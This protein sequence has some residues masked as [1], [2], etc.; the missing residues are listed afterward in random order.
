MKIENRDIIVVGIQPWDIE[1]GSNCKDIAA[2][3]S[4]HN[5]V[6]YINN[7]ISKHTAKN[8]PDSQQVKNRLE[9]N[10]DPSK[11][12]K[13]ISDNMWTFAPPV[14]IRSIN[15]LPS[16]G[17]FS[18]FN[19]INNRRMANEIKKA[20]AELG[21][22]NYIL[23][24]DQHM[25]LGQYLKEMLRP[26]LYIYYIRDNLQNVRYWNKHGR[27]LE[28]K[29]IAKADLVF[30]NSLLYEERARPYNKESYMVGQGCDTAL[31]QTS[32]VEVADEM[33][34]IKKPIIGYV[35]YL[36]SKRLDIEVI[37]HIA[38]ERPDYNVVLVG[39]EDDTFKNSALHNM[40][41]VIF[42]GPKPPET[43]PAYI[44]AFDIAINP[45]RLTKA[46]M[47]NY[48]RKIDEYLA[49]GIATLGTWTRAMEYFKDSVY[50]AKTKEEYIE[51]IDKALEEDND[52]LRAKRMEVGHLHSWT[53][54]VEL[55]Y[56]Y[57][58][59]K[60]SK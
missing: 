21:F 11:A 28:P 37:E 38:K 24:N 20:I 8:D 5:R 48:P 31:Y 41:N 44:K 45:Q 43:L 9:V 59:K 52:E 57:I 16:T 54:C 6:L 34:E 47:G 55:M 50:L 23:F 13:K 36:S 7:P 15:F 26:D 40:K 46:T 4:K 53:T 14:F 39:P 35:G 49:M 17:L 19:K 58:S 33:K 2:E 30:T 32:K 3:F 10:K 18:Y 42:L 22:K 56:D 12:L 29:L 60:E 27:I 1:I 25:F 51:L